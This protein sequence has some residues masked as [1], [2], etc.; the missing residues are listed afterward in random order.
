MFVVKKFTFISLKYFFK[1]NIMPK[2]I[3]QNNLPAYKKTVRLIFLT[4]YLFV[5]S[6]VSA[7]NEF[8]YTHAHTYRSEG[9]SGIACSDGGFAAAANVDIYIR[10]DTIVL[11]CED[12][13]IPYDTIFQDVI[14]SDILLVKTDAQGRIQWSVQLGDEG[15][16]RCHGIIETPDKG[17]LVCATDSSYTGRV[18]KFDHAGN[19]QWENWLELHTPMQI[20][21]TDSSFV[22][23]GSTSHLLNGT[24]I[25]IYTQ[26]ISPEGAQVWLKYYGQ[27]G[28][29][30]YLTGQFQEKFRTACKGL[31]DNIFI[32]GSKQNN[33]IWF[34]IDKDGNL[35]AEGF[36]SGDGVDDA[37][38][39]MPAPDG[40]Y[41]LLLNYAPV[42]V[43]NIQP[44]FL[45]LDTS[46]KILSE[47]AYFDNFYYDKAVSLSAFSDG[48][49]LISGLQNANIPSLSVLFHLKVNQNGI[50]QWLENVSVP[51][52]EFCRP[53][54]TVAL[55]G[56]QIF[57]TG[58]S[59]AGNFTFS[60]RTV[61]ASAAGIQY[62][63]IVRT[64]IDAIEN[65][66][67][68]IFPN[69]AKNFVWVENFDSGDGIFTIYNTDGRKM[70]SENIEGSKTPVSLSGLA[71]GMYIYKL[72]NR[73]ESFA[74]KLIISNY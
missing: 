10:T 50:P 15:S 64:R 31:D 38:S 18:I 34:D 16:D 36:V 63:T 21:E 47:I 67:V 60:K 69:P 70:L 43:Y 3:N 61:N 5:F 1:V 13:K 58:T 8:R 39:V 54:N 4:V 44:R 6:F 26:K 74:G 9:V 11:D 19:Q 42:P 68:H 29:D 37:V 23:S 71:N 56:N 52:A 12:C 30:S 51:D 72:T 2:F 40:G 24:D 17:I 27:N 53:V 28:T 49:F 66:S 33:L 46:G 73:R 45:K 7:Q 62:E 55:D 20:F 32:T 22:V 48:G 35:L 57:V 65:H 25:D 41:I 59:D 14:T